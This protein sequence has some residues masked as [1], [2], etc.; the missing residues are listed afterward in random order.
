MQLISF[1]QAAT[2]AAL[3]LTLG[4]GACDKALD[5]QPQN[6]IES[7][8]G[9]ATAG[10][11]A[12]ALIGCYDAVQATSYQQVSYPIWGDLLAGNV[13]HV[14]TFTTTYGQAFNNTITADNVE[15]TNMWAAIYSGIERCNY[16]LQQVD[17]I[18]D[19][20]LNKTT[21][22]AEARCLRAYNY[23][24]LL[25]YWGG[26]SNGYGYSGVGVPLRL[27]P[28]TTTE[29]AKQIARSSEDEVI[30]AIRNDLDFAIANL[31]TITL[32][33][34]SN[35]Q[36]R[37]SKNT[38]LALRAR[39]ELRLRNYADALKYAQQVPAYSNFASSVP[40][41]VANDAIWQLNFTTTDKNNMAFYWYPSSS[42][43]RN[44]FDPAVGFSG[45]HPSGDLRLPI[46]VQTSPAGTT[47]KYTNVSSG[48][49]FFSCVRYA[50]VVLTI[51]EAAAQTGDLATAA[52]NLNIIR[53]RAGLANTT[54]TTAAGLVS[55]ILLQRRLEFA[56]EGMYWFDLRRTNTVLTALPTYTQT[57][58]YLLP[59]PQRDVNLSNGLIAQ[60]TGY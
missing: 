11:A 17:N 39:F 2:R 13:R 34:T 57:F 3:L 9:Y 47:A 4:L 1:R 42:G 59:I 7:S 37:V 36:F 6:S 54:A 10:D 55:D 27:T 29:N 50:E 52:T 45:V 41:G 23:M 15:I 26:S 12:A 33:S 21:T 31:S 24:N 32:P 30:T 16:L 14:G 19:P 8:A 20:T 40:A 49:D 25:A 43:G 46:N 18:T 38:A 56:Y 53:K 60:N 51:A 44:E 22:Q 35:A 28:V 5:V 58:R 48:V